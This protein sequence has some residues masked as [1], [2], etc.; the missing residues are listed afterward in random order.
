MVLSDRRVS[1]RSGGFHPGD[2]IAGSPILVLFFF[3]GTSRERTNAQG[4]FIRSDF[5]T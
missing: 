5:S 3:A 2:K 4:K 1:L